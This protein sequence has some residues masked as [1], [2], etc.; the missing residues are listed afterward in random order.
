MQIYTYRDNQQL[1]PFTEADI[2]DKLAS[3]AISLQDN[4]WWEGQAGWTPL[5]QSSLAA[6]LA[7]TSPASAPRVPALGA[8]AVVAA[9][10]QET[11]KLAI[12]ALVCGCLSF[13]LSLLTSI[14]AIILGHLSLSQIKSHPGMKGQ[15]MALAGL[16]IGYINTLV[17]PFIS[18]VAISVL[19]ALGSQVKSV[20]STI[21]SQ[22]AAEQATQN[23]NSPDSSPPP[24]NH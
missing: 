24:V 1:G 23:N 14:P 15:G 3:G 18:I 22:V 5:G 17:L 8:S 4:V 16:I 19:I 12:W 9:P 2:K 6:T 13:F 10:V 21:N 11:S 20:F 7:P